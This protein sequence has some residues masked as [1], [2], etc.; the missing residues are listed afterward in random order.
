MGITYF[1]VICSLFIALLFGVIIALYLELLK[2][3]KWLEGRGVE[4]NALT[5]AKRSAEVRF[6]LFAENLSPL[7]KG[8]PANPQ[9]CLFL[10]KPIDFISFE[11]DCIK[12][13]EVKSMASK[14]S[15]SQRKIKKLIDE[16]KVKFELFRVNEKSELGVVDKE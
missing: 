5:S 7:L 10:G 16:G 1:G 2:Y 6:G 8:F 3:K 13:V 4:L 12:F 14:L 9:T 15:P 11:D